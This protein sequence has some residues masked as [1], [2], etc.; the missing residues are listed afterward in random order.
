MRHFKG[1]IIEP[2]SA[3]GIARGLNQRAVLVMKEE[4]VDISQ[5]ASKEV[6]LL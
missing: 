5:H 6:G 4:G 3:G 2:Y 1:N